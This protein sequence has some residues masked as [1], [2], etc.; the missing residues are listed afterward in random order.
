VIERGESQQAA[1]RREFHQ[2]FRCSAGT[3]GGVRE[4]EGYEAELGLIP[5]W[6]RV[7]EALAANRAVQACGFGGMR[8]LVR[9]TA[10]LEWL[11]AQDT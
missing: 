1:L 4:L 8:W 10:L 9:E 11:A 6:V 5:R 3:P 2:D 7:D